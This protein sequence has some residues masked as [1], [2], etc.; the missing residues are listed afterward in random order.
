MGIKI[1][2]NARKLGG[3]EKVHVQVVWIL[4][5][6]K[7]NLLDGLCFCSSFF[8]GNW[9]IWHPLYTTGYVKGGDP[10]LV[11]LFNSKKH[12]IKYGPTN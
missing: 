5:N 3:Y 6:K 7:S 8:Q 12:F 2:V 1:K 9:S 4:W 11:T 10:F